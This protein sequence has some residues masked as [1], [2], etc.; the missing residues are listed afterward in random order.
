MDKI[1]WKP[2][3]RGRNTGADDFVVCFLQTC[4]AAVSVLREKDANAVYFVVKPIMNHAPSSQLTS[5]LLSHRTPG[6][7]HVQSFVRRGGQGIFSLLPVCCCVTSHLFFFVFCVC[8]SRSGGGWIFGCPNAAD[9]MSKDL[10][11]ETEMIVVSV[12]YRLAPEVKFPGPLKVRTTSLLA[13]AMR[14]TCWW[15]DLRRSTFGIL[16]F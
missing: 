5:S 12:L 4:E 8:V 13:P 6:N 10:A 16:S 15:A 7:G 14:W 1:G 11:A 3:D 9:V 2:R